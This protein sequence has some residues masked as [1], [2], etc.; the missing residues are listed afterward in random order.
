[1][2]GGVCVTGFRVKHVIYTWYHGLQAY[3]WT[4][5]WASIWN[6]LRIFL[7]AYFFTFL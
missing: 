7:F 2:T 6:Q 5:C 1:L 3:E 4:K